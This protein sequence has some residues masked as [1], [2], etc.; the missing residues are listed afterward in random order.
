MKAECLCKCTKLETIAH[1]ET[2]TTHK[3]DGLSLL[4]VN[5]CI[6]APT[7]KVLEHLG[8][9]AG[10]ERGAVRAAHGVS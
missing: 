4:T 5:A 3:K 2:S 1:G 9:D 10:L 8:V 7:I 6:K